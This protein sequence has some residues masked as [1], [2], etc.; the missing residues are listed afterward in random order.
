MRWCIVVL[1]CACAAIANGQTALAAR[2][3]NGPVGS[4]DALI[5]FVPV[6]PGSPLTAADF[7][8]AVAGSPA[9]VI[10][11]IPGW[12]PSPSTDPGAG[13]VSSAQSPAAQQSALF[14]VPF[15][16]P[17]TVG[18]ATMTVAALG[19]DRLGSFLTGDSGIWINGMPTFISGGSGATE[20]LVTDRDVTSFLVQGQ[21]YVYFYVPATNGGASGLSFRVDFSVFAEPEWQ[22]NQTGASLDLDGVVGNASFPASVAGCTGV[23]VTANLSSSNVGMPWE[24]GITSPELGRP[25]SLG[26][27]PLSDGQV[28]NLRFSVPSVSYV[29]GLSFSSGFPAV[30]F[31]VPVAATAAVSMSAQMAVFDPSQGSG[32]SLSAIATLDAGA[33]TTVPLALPDDGTAVVD[34][35]LPPLCAAPV[36]FYGTTYAQLFVNSNGDVSFT[37]GHNTFVASAPLW[38]GQMPR[39]GLW[40]DFEPN[41]FGTVDVTRAGTAIQVNYTNV[42]EWG[43][44]GT[45]V[46]SYTV[47]FGG[48]LGL[49]AIRNFATDGT[50]GGTPVAAGISNGFGGTNPPLVS[51]DA[52]NGTG[53][54]PG[55]PTDSVTEFLLGM[56]PN[57][58]GWTSVAFPAGDGS[59]FIVN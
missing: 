53:L 44:G 4:S 8:A 1:T 58:S 54:I 33:P 50:W 35:T 11:P 46:T 26:A 15:T 23:P 10:A 24:V 57:A 25:R 27:P 42:T 31:S 13:W 3:G 32:L 30:S 34:V 40:S 7:A 19:D 48:P 29:N 28:A 51:F 17:T 56:L 36:T 43:T 18:S 16:V 47:E 41:L 59:S 5:T 21:N 22:V 14:A 9:Q 49:V 55:L 6:N 37:Q 39:V 52:L 12:A 2:S 38:Q 20:V 45:G